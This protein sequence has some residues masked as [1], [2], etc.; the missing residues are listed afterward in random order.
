MRTHPASL[1]GFITLALSMSLVL[2]PA[3]ARAESLFDPAG[4]ALL[5]NTTAREVGDILTVLISEN[6]SASRTVGTD[7]Q[8]EPKY[9]GGARVEGFF[10]IITGLNGVIEPLKALD[11]DP[12]EEFQSEASTTA[13]G[14]FTGRMTVIVREVLPNGHLRI[15]GTRLIQLNK[16]TETLSLTGIVRTMDI[17]ADNTIDSIQIADSQI[18]FTGKGIV[19]RSQKGGILGKIF[20]ILF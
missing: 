10:D 12:S 2:L 8:K 3:T 18:H 6:T 1:P 7:V 15:E 9:S 19:S 20:N 13:G 16:E 11:I 17:S 4:G 5:T 14:K